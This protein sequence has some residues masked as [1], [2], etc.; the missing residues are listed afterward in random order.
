MIAQAANSGSP[1]PKHTWWALDGKVYDVENKNF[2]KTMA[3]YA[4]RQNEI[5]AMV[6]GTLPPNL[7]FAEVDAASR[8]ATLN[9]TAFC[10]D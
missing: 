9:T 4:K 5:Y 8:N 10:S 6:K 7:R 3:K 1:K 2:Q